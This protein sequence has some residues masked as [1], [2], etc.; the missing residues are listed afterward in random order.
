LCDRVAVLAGGKIRALGTPATL[1]GRATAASIV[2]WAEDGATHELSTDVP[3]AAVAE[4][5]KRFVGEVPDLTVSRP[6]LEDIY[7]QLI[8]DER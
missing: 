5:A 4:L 7:L 3:T 1:G 8:G 6:T 2:R